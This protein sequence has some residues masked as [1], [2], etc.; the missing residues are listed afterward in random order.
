[1]SKRKI[2]RIDEAKCNGCG[3]CVPSCAEGA[4]QII[5]GKARL[6]K[7]QY[8]DGLGACLGECP[9]GA[10]SIEERDAA[11]F[12]EAAVATHLASQDEGHRHA[13]KPAGAVQKPAASGCPG[14]A[15]MMLGGG[16]PGSAARSVGV[17]RACD[18]PQDGGAR[19]SAPL[20]N[21]PVQLKL[22]P[23][24]APYLEGAELCI[25]ADC[26]AFAFADFHKRMLAGKVLLIGCPKLDDVAGYIEKLASIFTN[27]EIRSLDV[28]YMEVPCCFGLVHLVRQ[29]VAESGKVIPTTL[30]KVG[31]EGQVVDQVQVQ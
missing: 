9:Q 14:A 1:M 4:I 24:M 29:A 21:W 8:C 23:V 22:V 17:Q 19:V 2:V 28:V 18:T 6:V 30:T 10:I 16:C 13:E 27:N 20:L 15:A 12:D 31:I 26:T 25:A 7:E 5:E 11:A 3:L